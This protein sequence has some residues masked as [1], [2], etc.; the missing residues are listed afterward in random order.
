MR[1]VL[2][3]DVV[4]AA[5][6]SPKGAC[7]AILKAASLGLVALLVSVPLALEYEAICSDAEHRLASGLS[8]A[9]VRLF[10]DA[11]I[12]LAQPVQS[13]FLWR[14]QLRDPGDEMVLEAAVNGRADAIVTFNRR[15]YGT[16]PL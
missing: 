2:D 7:A 12:G 8:D 14:P 1:I 15:D 5:M 4:G 9:E 3:T 6:R 10:L 11:V 13:F 16:A